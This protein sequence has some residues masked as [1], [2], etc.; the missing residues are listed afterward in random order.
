M[1][2]VLIYSFVAVVAVGILIAGAV[3]VQA[4]DNGNYPPIIQKL[5]ER[6]NLNENEVREV[7]DENRQE[8]Y[9]RTQVNFEEKL[10]RLI[11]N[12]QFNGEQ[13]EAVMAKMNEMQE[14]YEEFKNLPPEERCAEMREMKEGMKEWSEENEIKFGT[15][16]GFNKG[17]GKGFG[18][19]SF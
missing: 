19:R 16:N 3:S 2:K 17:F 18:L 1:K 7:I 8:R 4:Q 14:K 15:L 9:Q 12:N 5:V 10:D 6:F 13:K 11:A